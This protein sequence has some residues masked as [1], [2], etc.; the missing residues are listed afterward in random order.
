MSGQRESTINTAEEHYG[1]FMVHIFAILYTI[2]A[3]YG[4]VVHE[5]G[6]SV[7]CPCTSQSQQSFQRSVLE[8]CFVVL[9]VSFVVVDGFL[10]GIQP[11]A[12]LS[13][14]R[15]GNRDVCAPGGW[16]GRG[17]IL[18]VPRAK[19][20]G[21]FWSCYGWRHTVSRQSRNK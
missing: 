2:A 14:T 9:L 18:T 3:A 11:R 1:W 20:S 21:V 5:P 12:R 8:F 4:D 6:A 17:V 10:L 7:S 19:V 15:P 16:V 13:A